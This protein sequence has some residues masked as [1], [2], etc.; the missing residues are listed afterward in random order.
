MN[1]LKQIIN[2]VNTSL[3]LLDNIGRDKGFGVA[4]KWVK[5]SA[6]PYFL[7]SKVEYNA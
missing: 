3:C 2:P 4:Q 5:I 1:Y 6:P 7:I